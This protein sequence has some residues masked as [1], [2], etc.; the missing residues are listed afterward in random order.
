MKK[1]ISY[2]KCSQILLVK[3][4]IIFFALVVVLIL[5]G[6]SSTI[7]PKK[8][9]GQCGL[10]DECYSIL[11]TIEDASPPPSEYRRLK[12]IN[13]RIGRYEDILQGFDNIKLQYK[14][15]Y[16]GIFNFIGYKLL[17]P[18]KS[19]FGQLT[20]EEKTQEDFYRYLRSL[21]INLIADKCDQFNEHY[22]K[23]AAY[24]SSFIK[25]DP[26]YAPSSFELYYDHR[27]DQI[28][29]DAIFHL[30]FDTKTIDYICMK[31]QQ[32][33][34]YG[35]ECRYSY[36]LVPNLMRTLTDVEKLYFDK[37]KNL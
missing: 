7:E 19:H 12:H 28:V 3:N 6:C 2:K 30:S 8:F 26:T 4:L 9:L 33:E 10:C 36:N 5:S 37:K 18:L 17:E 23:H 34:E 31:H 21:N 16:V 35:S 24:E 13:N 15:Q 1:T 32:E 29:K 25:L 11:R 20:Q 14:P 22:A 27:L